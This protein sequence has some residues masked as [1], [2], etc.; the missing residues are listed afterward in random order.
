M[1]EVIAEHKT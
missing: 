1:D